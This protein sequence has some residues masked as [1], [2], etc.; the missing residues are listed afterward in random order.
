[1]SFLLDVVYL[2]GLILFLPRL[3][4]EALRRGKVRQ[5]LMQ[6]FLGDVPRRRSC[7]PCVWFHAV[8]VGEVLMLRQ[9]VQR[10][11]ERHADWSV[12][13]STTT[14]SGMEM[15]RKHFPDR[16]VFYFPLDF[17]WAVDR[18]LRRVRPDLVVLAEQELWPNFI[19]AAGRAGAKVAVINGRMSPRSVRRYRLAFPLLRPALRRIDRLGA[20]TVPYARSFAAA[21]VPAERIFVTGSI[22]LDAIPTDRSNRATE[23]LRQLLG[24]EPDELVWVAGST[25]P[26]E[27]QLV[28]DVY[29]SLARRHPELRLLIVPRHKWRFDEVAELI[30]RAGFEL[31]RRSR[32]TGP[33]ARS[34]Q[35]GAAQARPAQV[36]QRSR[37]ATAATAGSARPRP[38]VLVDTLGELTAVWGLAEIAFVGG[39]FGK[40]GGQNMLEPAGYGSAVLFGPNVWNFQEAADMLIAEGGAIQVGSA[41]AL[42]EAVARLVSDASLRQ[43][44]GRRARATLLRRQGGVQRTLELLNELIGQ[45]APAANVAPGQ[46]RSTRRAGT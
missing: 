2:A 14:S 12:A 44:L 22:K 27:E 42:A 24:I 40:R 26:P 7:G 46:H 43:E 19:L 29:R 21:G 17:S 6:K 34:E 10:F 28:L 20:Q 25:S 4:Y 16:L 3:L 39:S 1:M 11:A 37:P 9:I 18:A 5:G 38:V 35:A 32:L 33:A 45:K 13:I 23:Q 36:R 30:A 41:R 8:S 15:A 31:I